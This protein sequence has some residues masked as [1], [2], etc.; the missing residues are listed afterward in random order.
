MG[1]QWN[2]YDQPTVAYYS[3]FYRMPL[4]SPKPS[5]ETMANNP[6]FWLQ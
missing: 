1:D 3:G 4:G 2:F 6:G 5:S